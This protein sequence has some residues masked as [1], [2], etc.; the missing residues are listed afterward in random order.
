MKQFRREIDPLG[1]VLVP[2]DR[3]YGAHAARA[4]ENFPVKLPGHALGDY[5]PLVRSLVLVK[6]A[7]AAA[8]RDSGFLTLEEYELISEACRKILS[9]SEYQSAFPVHIL[10]GGGGTSANMNANEVI[11]HVAN[12]LASAVGAPGTVINPIDHV[13]RNQ[14]TNDVYPSACRMAIVD[15]SGPLIESVRGLVQAYADLRARHGL[16]PRLVRTCFQDAVATTFDQ[17]FGAYQGVIERCLVNLERSSGALSELSVG[18]GIAGQPD[19]TPEGYREA[20]LP[21]LRSIFDI[22]T[23]TLTGNYADAAQNNDDLLRFANELEVL[24]RVLIKQSN[25]LRLLSSGPEGGFGEIVLPPLQAGS[26]AMPGKINPVI[27]EFVIQCA[28][29]TIAATTACGLATSHAEL[30]LDVWEGVYVYNLI[31]SVQLLESAISVLNSRCLNGLEVVEETNRLHA[32]S[33]TSQFA[34]MAQQTS[35]HAALDELRGNAAP[36]DDTNK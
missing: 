32:Q 36:A 10:Q 4:V 20:L 24:A 15:V 27:P 1:E 25:D 31:T 5:E 22:E 26:S 23:I 12:E 29:Q 28:I 18:G 14:S 2:D 34:A 35:Y 6:L 3:P 21:H 7:A 9:W 19:A 8:N 11:T 33:S 17:L 30:D 13:N 16:I